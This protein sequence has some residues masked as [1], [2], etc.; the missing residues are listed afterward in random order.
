MRFVDA[1]PHGHALPPPSVAPSC[2]VRSTVPAT[3]AEG[4][5]SVTVVNPDGME[6]T[7]GPTISVRGLLPHAGREGHQ[8]LIALA[9]LL[10][11]RVAISTSAR[12]SHRTPRFSFGLAPTCAV[13]LGPAPVISSVDP[14]TVTPLSSA[15][16]IIS[17][18]NF[19]SASA[20]AAGPGG[21]LGAGDATD[22]LLFLR[23]CACACTGAERLPRSR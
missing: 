21:A 20:A 1:P 5:Y 4:N 22:A 23:A 19:R 10:R 6:S 13:P 11:E 9:T 2:V 16:L 14:A 17:G 12:S 8:T 15:L 3:L 7:F 18:A